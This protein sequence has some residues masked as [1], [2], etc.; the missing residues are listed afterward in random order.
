MSAN[1]A[2]MGLAAGAL[3]FLGAQAMGEAPAAAAQGVR[4]ASAATAEPAPA[5]EQTGGV[6]PAAGTDSAPP[7]AQGPKER[8]QIGPRIP[9]ER[10]D[11]DR[12]RMGNIL[13]DR[14]QRRFSIPGRVIWE[15]GPLEF[16]AVVKG[17]VKS[18]EA[19]VE[20]DTD[21]VQFNLACLLIGL[22]A[23]FKR[24]PSFHFDPE[25]VRGKTAS[26]WLSWTQDGASREV[27][28]S[29]MFALKEGQ[30]AGP[31][32]I[33]TGSRTVRGRY[34]AAQDGTLIGFAHDPASIIEHREGLG[35]GDYGSVGIK[36]GMLPA[37]GTDLTLEVRWMSRREAGIPIEGDGAPPTGA[38]D[39][40]SKDGPPAPGQ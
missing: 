32:W 23:D 29:E 13:I 39:P 40:A 20:L 5:P 19:L 30:A 1:H 8:R 3:I 22:D 24:G 11:A 12:V 2:W 6:A 35:L 25:P 15:D 38:P 37:K 7:P 18:Y 21:A 10:V 28:L 14:R 17:G 31:I 27:S 33:Y 16:V 9:I 34:L 26:V 4:D 36:P